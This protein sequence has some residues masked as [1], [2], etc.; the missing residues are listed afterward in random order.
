MIEAYKYKQLRDCC[1]ALKLV[2][3]V[4]VHK[5]LVLLEDCMCEAVIHL[6]AIIEN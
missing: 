1:L 5:V 6:R 4:E 3:V 2:E